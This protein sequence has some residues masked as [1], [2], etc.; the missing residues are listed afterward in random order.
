MEELGCFPITK[1]FYHPIWRALNAQ[2]DP[3]EVIK[4]TFSFHTKENVDNPDIVIGYNLK[5]D[6]INKIHFNPKLETKVRAAAALSWLTVGRLIWCP[7]IIRISIVAS[8]MVE[9][10]SSLD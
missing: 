7:R 3:R 1:D 5:G 9:S 4:T 6:V 2:V 8:R 10:L